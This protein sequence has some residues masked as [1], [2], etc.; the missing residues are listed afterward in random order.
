MKGVIDNASQSSGESLAPHDPA[1]T[2]ERATQVCEQPTPS[3]PTPHGATYLCLCPIRDLDSVS[4]HSLPY[5]CPLFYQRSLAPR[6]A[7]QWLYGTRNKLKTATP[8]SQRPL[9][10]GLRSA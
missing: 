10:R 6:I 1:P 9:R 8:Y 7:T 3:N 5:P 2:A 4:S